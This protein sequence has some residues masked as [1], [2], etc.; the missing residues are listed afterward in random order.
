M[1]NRISVDGLYSAPGGS[2]D[3]FV[4]DPKVDLAAHELTQPDTVLFGRVTYQLFEQVWPAVAADP[5]APE[6][7]RT[8]AG[9]LNR[10]TKIVYSRTL[11]NVSWQNSTLAEGDVAEHVRNLR[12]EN[13]SD[14]IIFG[15][16][17]I[18]R[19]LVPAELIDEYVVIVTPVV[20]GTGKSLFSRVEK[21]NLELLETRSFDSG[22]AL[23]HYRHVGLS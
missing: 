3:W 8:I 15:S 23:L 13:G 7:A 20:L 17:T 22:N 19:Q 18:V 4:R 9:E 5:K 11:R 14:I 16:G 1:F 6:A 12:Q 2:I 10:M 21:F